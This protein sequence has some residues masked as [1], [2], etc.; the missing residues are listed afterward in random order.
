MFSDRPF[1]VENIAR[2]NVS[3]GALSKKSWWSE[4]TEYIDED[5]SL[6]TKV[7]SNCPVRRPLKKILAE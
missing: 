3:S 6:T 1:G 4:F 5:S 7:T 2:R